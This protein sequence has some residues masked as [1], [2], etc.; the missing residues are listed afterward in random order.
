ML[1]KITKLKVKKKKQTKIDKWA[2]TLKSINLYLLVYWTDVSIKLQNM[3]SY[4]QLSSVSNPYSNKADIHFGLYL[5][6][7]SQ[8]Q[9]T[10]I[11]KKT[12][13]LCSFQFIRVAF[14]KLSFSVAKHITCINMQDVHKLLPDLFLPHNF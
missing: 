2:K 4:S 10:N 11:L 7:H 3:I 6:I 1:L 9:R 14:L 5:D 8:F 13:E 12:E